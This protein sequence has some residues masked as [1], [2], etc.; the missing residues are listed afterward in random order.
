[1]RWKKSGSPFV[2]GILS[3]SDENSLYYAISQMGYKSTRLEL[4]SNDFLVVHAV[5]YPLVGTVA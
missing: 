5:K 3:Y 4:Y 2:K 1:M